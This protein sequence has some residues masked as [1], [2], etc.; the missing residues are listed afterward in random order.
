MNDVIRWGLMG[1]GAILDRFMLGFNNV[2]NNKVVSIA[3]RTYE[4]A[5]NKSLKYNI[6]DINTYEELVKRDDINVVYI[7]TVH[8]G[9]KELA[10][11]AMNNHKNVLVEKP[12]SINAND[13]IEL[14]TC[15]KKNDVFLMEAVWTK[16]FPIYEKIKEIINNGTI[17]DINRIDV[18]FCFKSNN[19]TIN[20]RLFDI[21]RAGGSLLDVGVYGLH[22]V[23]MFIK[24]D[25]VDIE[26]K[27]VIDEFFKV[28]L[29]NEIILKYQNNIKANIECSIVQEKPKNAYIY[30][31]KG[32][33]EIPYFYKASE[34]FI[35]LGDLVSRVSFE[36]LNSDKYHLD[37]GYQY[38]IKHVCDC[39]NNNLKESPLV[40]LEESLK[41]LKQCDYIRS[42]IG[43]RYP[44]E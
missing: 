2:D 18:S 4:S 7:N 10:L 19:Q 23:N 8:N 40:P 26:C 11:L 38:E 21:N 31:T 15:A 41:V 37:E 17:G 27:S 28:D 6:N 35:H 14:I 20:S 30:G 34:A 29:S 43:I 5:L 22:F 1:A 39:L 24:D 13:F 44:F 12:A 33:I 32:Y 16:C 3:S 42:K 9:H 25:P 36:V